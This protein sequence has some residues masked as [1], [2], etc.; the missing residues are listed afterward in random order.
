VQEKYDTKWRAVLKKTFLEWRKSITVV[1]LKKES[2]MKA[3]CHRKVHL[4]NRVF[5]QWRQWTVLRKFRNDQKKETL[6]RAVEALNKLKMQRCFHLWSES[7]D[8][9]KLRN[10]Q[11]A[12]ANQHYY[13][14][15]CKVVFQAWQLHK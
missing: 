3:V 5:T 12:T 2:K 7:K 6:N 14:R 1:V 4:E 10:L 8:A 13:N 9:S 15:I 11:Q